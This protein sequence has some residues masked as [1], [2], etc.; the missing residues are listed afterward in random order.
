MRELLQD[1]ETVRRWSGLLLA[2]P[3]A[4][5]GALNALEWWRCPTSDALVFIGL[6]IFFAG[7]G[8]IE[9]FFFDR[10]KLPIM[11]W[12]GAVLFTMLAAAALQ[13]PEPLVIGIAALIGA[14]SLAGPLLALARPAH[15]EPLRSAS[16]ASAASTDSPAAPPA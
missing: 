5:I 8:I 11:T 4:A 15:P 14:V 2:V 1:A 7:N 6:S 3:F 12:L 10:D 13:K 16:G 9:F